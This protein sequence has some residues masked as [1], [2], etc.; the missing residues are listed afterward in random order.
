M[1]NL[2]GVTKGKLRVGLLIDSW[3]Q[4]RWVQR[5]GFEW[6]H[7]L[8]QEPGRLGRRYLVEGPPF[9]ARLLLGSLLRRWS[10]NAPPDA[11]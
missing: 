11:R 7:R 4:P 10:G 8:V 9:A 3:L 2:D 6:L 1:N 5:M